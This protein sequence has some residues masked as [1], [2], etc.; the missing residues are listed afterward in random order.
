MKT[1]IL[2]IIVLLLISCSNTTPKEKFPAEA[3]A[4]KVLALDGTSITF[5]EVLEK[6]KGKTVVI[7]IWASWC[8]DCLKGLPKVKLLQQQVKDKDVVFLFLSLDRTQKAW[9]NAINTRSI[10]GEHYY[11]PS[12]WK[13]AIGNAVDLDWIPRYMVV[14]KKGEIIV[15]KAIKADDENILNA[16]KADQ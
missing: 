5:G 14:N 10:T 4:D 9:K 7:D 12:G 3:L 16:I 6:Y 13:G 11:V 1:K 15:Y 8:G 2:A